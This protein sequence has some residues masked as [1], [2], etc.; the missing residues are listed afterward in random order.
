MS[1]F[2]FVKFSGIISS[3]NLSLFLSS[4]SPTMVC[5]SSW[6]FPVSSLNFVH[7][8]SIFIVPHT[9]F[10]LSYL[11]VHWFFCLLKSTFESYWNFHLL[12]YFWGRVF[13]FYIFPL[14]IFPFCSH[15]IF[16][17]DPPSSLPPGRDTFVLVGYRNYFVPF[18]EWAIRVPTTA[19]REHLAPR[20]HWGIAV[21]WE[22]LPLNSSFSS[23]MENCSQ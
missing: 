2:K 5:W 11:L 4:W 8:Y 20:S 23:Q 18:Y 16:F 1:F 3:K 9:W 6:R 13:C 17:T 10:Q 19:H 12:S 22:I 14:L 15:T 7:L 21:A